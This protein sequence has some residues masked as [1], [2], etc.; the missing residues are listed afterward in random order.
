MSASSSPENSPPS[1]SPIQSLFDENNVIL[2]VLSAMEKTSMK[3]E[4]DGAIVSSFWARAVDF[5]ATFADHH[6][7][8][9]E[10]VLFPH[11]EES[12]FPALENLLPTMHEDHIVTRDRLVT[13]SRFVEAKD[14]AE[15]ARAAGAYAL[16]AQEHLQ[17]ENLGLYPLAQ[18]ILESRKDMEIQTRLVEFDRERWGLAGV[19]SRLVMARDLCK[20]SRV[21]FH[22]MRPPKIG[23]CPRPTP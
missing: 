16:L 23:L 2:S 5:L 12:G 19:G 10:V 11:L 21:D 20:E 7:T 13:L 22:G 4:E 1:T 8:K 15:V 3:L 18:R 17:R 6:H 9:E 14:R